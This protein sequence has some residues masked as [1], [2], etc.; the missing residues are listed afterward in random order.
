VFAVG[1]IVLP[2]RIGGD[3]ASGVPQTDARAH[4]THQG[5]CHWVTVL[6]A[7]TRGEGTVAVKLATGPFVRPHQRAGHDDRSAGGLAVISK[8]PVRRREEDSL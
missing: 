5:W 2:E 4:A 6:D 8:G 7:A 1:L 3:V